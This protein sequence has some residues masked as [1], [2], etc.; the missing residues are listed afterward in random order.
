[1]KKCPDCCTDVP[2][3]NFNRNSARYDGLSSICKACSRI[4]YRNRY[5]GPKGAAERVR[6]K[7]L[8]RRCRSNP[9]SRA[10][11]LACSIIVGK[12]WVEENRQRVRDYHQKRSHTF[13]GRAMRA[14]NYAV[15]IGKLPRISTQI[16]DCGLPARHYHH[17]SY[18]KEHWLKVIPKCLSCHGE[19]RREIIGCMS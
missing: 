14:V 9:I 12:R 19:T 4:R 1:M 15:R 7:L 8:S 13:K 3:S 11:I 16:C 2:E 17:E 18:R 10:K 6:L 5:Y